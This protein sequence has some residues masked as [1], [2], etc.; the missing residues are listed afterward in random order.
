MSIL[1]NTW[2]AQVVKCLT[3]N[4]GS[5]HDLRVVILSPALDSM[6]AVESA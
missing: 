2:V 3:D 4:F 5:G 6:L 1:G